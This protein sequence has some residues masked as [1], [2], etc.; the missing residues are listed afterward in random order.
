M[1]QNPAI[2]VFG[3]LFQAGIAGPNFSAD[4]ASRPSNA[5]WASAFWR[6]WVSR[7]LKNLFQISRFAEGIPV[8]L[9]I[10]FPFMFDPRGDFT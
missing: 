10:Y 3:W 8:L 9:L 6:L 4:A 7:D 1:N 5:S 2:I